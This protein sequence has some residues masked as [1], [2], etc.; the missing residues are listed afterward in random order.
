MSSSRRG[1]RDRSRG[2]AVTRGSSQLPTQWSDW[3]WHDESNC[4]RRYR[5]DYRGG[6]M[7]DA[8]LSLD[9]EREGLSVD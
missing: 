4:R 5:L 8:R 9:A 6:W 3:E 1:E 7:G 2:N